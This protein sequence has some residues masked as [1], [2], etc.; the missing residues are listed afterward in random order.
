MCLFMK[1]RQRHATASDQQI[2][3][4]SD[5]VWK[6]TTHH[7]HHRPYIKKRI[8]TWSKL[9][10]L[11]SWLKTIFQPAVFRLANHGPH[12]IS[13]SWWY[14]QFCRV[15][16]TWTA[17]LSSFGTLQLI[18]DRSTPKWPPFFFSRVH[19]QVCFVYSRYI[20]GSQNCCK[21]DSY[22]DTNLD[23]VV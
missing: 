6:I 9:S 10:Y 2:L 4:F 14:W 22:S 15:L 12:L 5:Y 1:Y 8:T 20:S 3:L 16:A 23:L 7:S 18:P 13:S 19:L 21:V 11:F 17:R